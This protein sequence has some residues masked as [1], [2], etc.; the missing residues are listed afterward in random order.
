MTSFLFFTEAIYW[1][2]F[3]CI[4]LK[5]KK[6]FLNSFLHFLSLDSIF[7]IFSKKMTFVADVF[8]NLQTPKEVLTKMSKKFYFTEPFGKKHGK[9]VE[10]LT[11]LN[12]R[13]FIMFIDPCECN[14]VLKSVFEWYARP[15]DCLL[16]LSLPITSIL[17]LTEATYCNIFRCNYLKNEKYFL[18][19]FLSCVFQIEIQFWT[20]SK[21][22]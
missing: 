12:E 9:R 8:L 3:R 10:T 13:T 11:K 7:N 21:K 6:Y 1:N 2:I 16:T 22:R 18:V 14:S 5:N 17:F 15:Y 19:F 20:F 4:G